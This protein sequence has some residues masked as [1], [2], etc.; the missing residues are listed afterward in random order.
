MVGASDWIHMGWGMG[1]CPDEA[2]GA[3]GGEGARAWWASR[4]P[5]GEAEKYL[6]GRED[7]GDKVPDWM[8]IGRASCRERV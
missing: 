1:V 7:V 3:G 5:P 6:R 2:G 8:E 4:A